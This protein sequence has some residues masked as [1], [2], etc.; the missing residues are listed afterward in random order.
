MTSRGEPD[1]RSRH[2]MVGGGVLGRLGAI[3]A[4]SGR[5]GPVQGGLGRS[6][7]VWAV[8]GRSGPSGPV[9]AV[10]T[11]AGPAGWSR[12]SGPV[13]IRRDRTGSDRSQ[14]GASWTG[15]AGVGLGGLTWP[16]GGPDQCGTGSSRLTQP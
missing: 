1:G 13:G 6:G 5:S 15:L 3:G 12:R 8:L 2:G 16:E 4:H 9:R 11:G 7:P 10:W 14:P